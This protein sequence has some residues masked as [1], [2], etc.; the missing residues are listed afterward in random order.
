MGGS[1]YNSAN[2]GPASS[3]LNF[4]T[5]PEAKRLYKQ[6][7]RYF[8]SRWG[9]SPNLIAIELLQE[10]DWMFYDME[11]IS[12]SYRDQVIS[13]VKTWSA[14]IIS[15]IRGLDPYGHLITTSG[16]QGID[17]VQNNAAHNLV[18][19]GMY[20]AGPYAMAQNHVYIA[21]NTS[22]VSN[23]NV[24]GLKLLSETI[25]NGVAK[26]WIIGEWGLELSNAIPDT[27]GIGHHNAVWVLMMRGTTPW[28]WF[29]LPRF[30]N[31]NLLAFPAAAAFLVGE[32]FESH[33]GSLSYSQMRANVTSSDSRVFTIGLKGPT[34]ALIWVQN[35]SSIE[36]SAVPATLSNIPITISD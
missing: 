31:S 26:P 12:L 29:A 32:D 28:A 24:A 6:E 16:G 21:Q 23:R 11:K 36:N 2:G 34:R 19:N 17:S 25:Q 30:N 8:I 14:E 9:Y 1:P 33:F 27:G 5:N 35:L 13:A 20:D 4:F 15:Y 18:V 3:T 10:L 7:I 22:N